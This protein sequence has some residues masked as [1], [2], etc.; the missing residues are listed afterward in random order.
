M[1]DFAALH[2]VYVTDMDVGLAR[3]GSA[4][5]SAAWLVREH[6]YGAAD[7][8]CDHWHD[9]AGFLTHHIAITWQLERS[10][11][12]IDP[13]LAAHYWDYTIDSTLA[14]A[15]WRESPIFDPDW[16]GAASPGGDTQRSA[17]AHAPSLSNVAGTT[18]AL[19]GQAAPDV[20]G[21]QA[22]ATPPK[23]QTGAEPPPS[24]VPL[25]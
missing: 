13:S 1:T 18:K 22:P 24:S 25:T 12:S 7:H 21:G 9:D 4:F 8:E 6:L 3:Y 11:Q 15:S 14:G 23:A 5:R 19:D 16:F 10:L 17:P 2:T 20:S